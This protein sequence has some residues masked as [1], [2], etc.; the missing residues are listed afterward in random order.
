MVPIAD[1]VS[2]S[3]YSRII[4]STPDATTLGT[5]SVTSS[6]EANGAS[7]VAACGSRGLSFRVASVTTASVPSDPR[8]S[9]VRS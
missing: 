8:I 1:R 5:A 2:M 7:T 9:W 6:I 3:M 4:G